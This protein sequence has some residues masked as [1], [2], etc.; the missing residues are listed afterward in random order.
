[1]VDR[2]IT[3]GRKRVSAHIRGTANAPIGG[4]YREIT[5]ACHFSADAVN[6]GGPPGHLDLRYA[7]VSRRER[8]RI[9][10]ES[11]SCR[12]VAATKC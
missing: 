4:D 9:S 12:R 5:F 11:R 6:A 1:M 10:T 8:R 2:V 3:L 7:S